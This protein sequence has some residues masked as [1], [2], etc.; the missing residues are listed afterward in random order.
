MSKKRVFLFFC[1]I[2]LLIVSE[3]VLLNELMV[4]DNASIM[5]ISSAGLMASVFFI[6]RF[7]N[8]WRNSLK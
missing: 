1:S 7:Y 4:S 5:A 6:I 8:E 2:V 3:Y